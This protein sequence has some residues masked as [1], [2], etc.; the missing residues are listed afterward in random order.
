MVERVGGFQENG[1]SLPRNRYVGSSRRKEAPF[2][3]TQ[4]R[5][6]VSS[7][8]PALVFRAEGRNGYAGSAT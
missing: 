2:V 4:Y 5:N 3:S 1:G 8:S 7:L 6:A